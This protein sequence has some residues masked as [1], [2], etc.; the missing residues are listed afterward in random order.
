MRNFPRQHSLDRG[1]ITS[2]MC[3]SSVNRALSSA[4]KHQLDLGSYAQIHP[5]SF[6]EQQSPHNPQSKSYHIRTSQS[7][8]RGAPLMNT[9]PPEYWQVSSPYAHLPKGS[10]GVLVSKDKTSEYPL[11][12]Q[13]MFCAPR[14]PSL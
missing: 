2:A 4:V 9:S 5:H 12:Q 10:Q 14:T 3:R 1:R 7:I 13:P 11:M 8:T 6:D